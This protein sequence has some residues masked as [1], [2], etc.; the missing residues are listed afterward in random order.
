MFVRASDIISSYQFR[1][2]PESAVNE[3]KIFFLGFYVS[4]NKEDDLEVIKNYASPFI[5]R[6]AGVPE[7]KDDMLWIKTACEILFE[8]KHL[9]DQEI[10]VLFKSNPQY[11]DICSRIMLSA[12]SFRKLEESNAR[13]LAQI[14]SAK[15]NGLTAQ[16]Q[17]FKNLSYFRLALSS[18]SPQ[19]FKREIENI[20]AE[21]KISGI[22]FYPALSMFATGAYVKTGIIDEKTAAERLAARLQD[23]SSAAFQE[24]KTAEIGAT[25]E[26][27]EKLVA[28]NLEKGMI[29]NAFNTTI[30]FILCE[31]DDKKAAFIVK[32]L[33]E[34]QA[35]L[36]REQKFFLDKVWQVV[37]SD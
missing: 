33:Y 5:K 27:Y 31:R 13:K 4:L 25:P 3:A 22:S 12:L 11:S 19:A 7:L 37:I 26:Q 21:P 2:T 17:T 9:S 8:E 20:L 15:T 14:I 35:F 30:Y 32:S 10:E 23:S 1:F 34:N 28:R 36:S 24:I 16:S 18:H 29:E 6:F